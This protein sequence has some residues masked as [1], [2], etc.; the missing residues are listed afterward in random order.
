MNILLMYETLLLGQNVSDSEENHDFF[1]SKK[2]LIY[3]NLLIIRFGKLFNLWL[4]FDWC[5]FDLT[6]F[7]ASVEWQDLKWIE[8][9]FYHS[10]F[11][12]VDKDDLRNTC[13]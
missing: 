5:Q 11:Y 10:G 13:Y 6:K 7:S 4:R 9:L 3:V 1:F 8:E 12:R 2:K